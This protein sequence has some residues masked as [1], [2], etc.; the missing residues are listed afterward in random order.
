MFCLCDGTSFYACS[1]QI[2]RPELRNKIVLVA[3]N[4]DG[5]ALSPTAKAAGFKKFTPLFEIQ[6]AIRKHGATVLSSN[7]PPTIFTKQ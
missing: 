7:H 4:N 1:E 5:V 3:S 2:F 6:D